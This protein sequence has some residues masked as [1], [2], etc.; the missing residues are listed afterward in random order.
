MHLRWWLLLLACARPLAAADKPDV[1]SPMEVVIGRH[2]F[3]DF[4]PPSDFYEVVSLRPTENGTSIER[5][6]ATPAGLPCIQPPTVE[7]A[8]A[9]VPESVSS[10]LGRK[11]PCA[12]PEKA[13]RRERK[14]CKNCLV[15]SGANVVMQVRCG[16]KVRR[17]RMDILDRDLF[18]AGSRPPENTSW[19]MDLL[20]R[21]DRPLGPRAVDR[22]MFS[23]PDPAASPASI[24]ASAVDALE[25]GTFDALVGLEPGGLATLYAE[26]RVVRTPPTVALST[27]A[28][29]RPIP[30]PVLQYPDIAR[31]ARVEGDV[32]FELSV[33]PDGA[34]SDVQIR[35]GPTLLQKSVQAIAA[36][37][38]FPTA[39]DARV[40]DGVV[41][42]RMNCTLAAKP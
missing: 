34:V 4:G 19:T 3:F 2:T 12:I 21:L 6:M 15:F 8:T 9:S 23:V 22:R 26:S 36:S 29:F 11:N 27:G 37:W 17:I 42:F 41:A 1:A 16:E 24:A 18:D 40:F 5:V 32:S 20:E 14:R 13:L 33:A 25:K 38:R 10:L 30:E 35:S 28:A 7:V 39:A 31:L